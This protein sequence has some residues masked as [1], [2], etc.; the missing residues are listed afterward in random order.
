MRAK[1]RPVR[2]AAWTPTGRQA[3]CAEG[4]GGF[5][6]GLAIGETYNGHVAGASKARARGGDLSY[7]MEVIAGRSRHGK[8]SADPRPVGNDCGTWQLC[9]T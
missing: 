6:G 7:A 1:R 2:N 4:F 8:G 3:R 5:A 9:Q